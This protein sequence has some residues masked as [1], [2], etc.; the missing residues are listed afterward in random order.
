MGEC[1]DCGIEL[2]M[3]NHLKEHIKMV[4]VDESIKTEDST[5]LGSLYPRILVS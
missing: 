2:K 4:Y 5:V 3:N 1:R